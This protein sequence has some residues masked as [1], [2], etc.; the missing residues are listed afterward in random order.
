MEPGITSYYGKDAA[1]SGSGSPLGIWIV[2]E[3]PGTD[4]TV[5]RDVFGCKL[6]HPSATIAII[7]KKL[8]NF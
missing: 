4:K 2:A 3:F 1:A 5:S 8:I 7:G 6:Y